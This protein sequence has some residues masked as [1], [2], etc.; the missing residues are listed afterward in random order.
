[1]SLLVILKSPWSDNI[2]KFCL[3]EWL[4]ALHCVKIKIVSASIQEVR[5]LNLSVYIIHYVDGILL[6][7]PSDEVLLQAFALL[8]QQTL[9]FW[10]RCCS[11]KDSKAI[12]FSIFGTSA[13]S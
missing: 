3:K 8:I 4:I 1:M 5:T 2:E 7:D 6:A 9:K 13:I 12:S 10:S 11:R